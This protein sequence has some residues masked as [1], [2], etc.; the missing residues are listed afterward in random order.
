MKS[1]SA[2]AFFK[3]NCERFR[4]HFNE[5]LELLNPLYEPNQPER[6]VYYASTAHFIAPLVPE[7]SVFLDVGCGW[8]GTA[9]VLH[10]SVRY[11]GVDFCPQM[12]DKADS[13]ENAKFYLEDFHLL[14]FAD[15]TFD[16]VL[17]NESLFY[18]NV[19]IAHRE[20]NRV[21]K[22]NG[23]FYTK[24]WLYEHVPEGELIYPSLYCLTGIEHGDPNVFA[25][26]SFSDYS[27]ELDKYFTHD[28][29][30][31]ACLRPNVFLKYFDFA[32]P[33]LVPHKVSKNNPFEHSNFSPAER[34]RFMLELLDLFKNQQVGLPDKI[35]WSAR[36]FQVC[37][38][39]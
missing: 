17:A 19:E 39:K 26:K 32:F 15:S 28:A 31:R 34:K 6:G 18:G 36:G 13:Y 8:G 7:G 27:L 11:H 2:L 10:P 23:V 9:S 3:N 21:L 14:P 37:S 20:I 25:F 29:A 12:L 33:S 16:F 1:L 38:K 22:P 35:C 30:A 24:M 5:C 4:S